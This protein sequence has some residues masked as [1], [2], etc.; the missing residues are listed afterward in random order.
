MNEISVRYPVVDKV[1]K[2]ETM[3]EHMSMKHMDNSRLISMHLDD[4]RV[5]LDGYGR[6]IYKVSPPSDLWLGLRSDR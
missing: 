1:F 3:D 6:E 2:G 5:T 4:K